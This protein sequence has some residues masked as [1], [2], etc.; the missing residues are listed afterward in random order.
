[1]TLGVGK[2]HRNIQ[3]RRLIF[4]YLGKP[5]ITGADLLGLNH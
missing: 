3:Q 4:L 1:M 2:K 5:Q